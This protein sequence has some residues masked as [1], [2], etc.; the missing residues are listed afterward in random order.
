M[1]ST[2]YNLKGLIL[3]EYTCNSDGEPIGATKR[4]RVV[5]F[6]TDIVSQAEIESAIDQKMLY[7]LEWEGKVLLLSPRQ[8]KLLA[9]K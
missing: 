2:F 5:L 8:A 3:T 4:E 1:A 7:K 9:D 6:N